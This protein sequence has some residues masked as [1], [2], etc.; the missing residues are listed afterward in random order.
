[1]KKILSLFAVLSLATACI[2]PYQ[3]DLEEA[4]QG[5][6]VV[7]G[8]LMIGE[9]ST[10][11]IGLMSSLWPGKTDP[12][13]P[14]DG[15]WYSIGRSGDAIR[16]WAEDDAGGV[17]E[18]QLV[19]ND[20]YSPMVP[21]IL[22]LEN[23]PSD[24]KYRVCVQMGGEQYS[25]DWIKPLAP[26]T[27]KRI[28]FKASNTLSNQDVT[29]QVSLEG[30][31]DATG[32]ILL[33]YDETWRFHT[34][35]YPNYEYDYATNSVSLRTHPWDRYWCWKTVDPHTQIPLDY[36]QM[37]GSG[38]KDY[39]LLKFSRYDNRNHSRYSIRVK[40]RTIDRETYKFLSHLEESTESGDN[41]FT[42]NPGEVPGNLRCETDPDRMVMGYVTVAVTTSM[43]AYNGSQFLLSRQPS[44]YDLAYPDQ[45][46]RVSGAPYWRDFYDM[47]YMPLIENNL[48]PSDGV[49]MGPYGWGWASCYDCVA[50]G[51]TLT[52]PDFW[53]E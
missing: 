9:P 21:Y 47:G 19:A 51:G 44:P 33:S 26:P 49:Q 52:A 35:Y 46:P 11:Q 8:N 30:G 50:A 12:G 48:P 32:Y 4:P 41:L 10:V 18:G 23:A 31:P 38:V 27:F 45:W 43:R 40:A 36:T 42:P 17:Y 13:T 16:V 1:M 25:S 6:L 53:E 39:P 5:V 28:S 15:Y 7:D 29:V 37:A 24:R 22:P 34:D 20:W 2:Y 14:S 3:P